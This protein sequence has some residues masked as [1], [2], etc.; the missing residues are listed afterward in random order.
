MS[1]FNKV[2]DSGQRQEF[3]TGSVRDSRDGKGRFDLISPVALKRLA[4]HFENG[5]KKYGDRNWEKGQPLTR[6]LDSLIRHAYC[7]L[8][9]KKDED[10]AS[11]IAWNAM[12][13]VHTE[14]MIKR[15]ILSKELN[16]MPNYLKEEELK[17]GN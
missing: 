11:A 14:E 12:A 10:H 17:N 16:D 1:E 8:E 3:N 7:L 15:G 13:Y 5:S 4:K 9:G 2:K 6:Y